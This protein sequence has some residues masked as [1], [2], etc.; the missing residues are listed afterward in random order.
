MKKT[1]SIIL[2]VIAVMSLLFCVPA[3]AAGIDGTFITADDA[4]KAAADYLGTTVDSLSNL[5]CKEESIEYASV[6]GISI[7][8][9]QF[10]LSFRYNGVSYKVTVDPVGV[11]RNYSY[12][13]NKVIVPKGA[14]GYMTEAEAKA[15]ATD[16]AGVSS[17]DAIF[18][19]S[20]FVVE[21]YVG[22]YQFSFLGKT[23]QVSAK[24]NASSKSADPVINV[25]NKNAIVMF[26]IRL[27][28]K[29]AAMFG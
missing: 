3:S 12:D 10:N 2:A 14:S 21:D 24:V 16:A 8:A 28:A 19:S 9:K 25:E 29:I 27:F 13:S 23:Q 26:F 7:S 15:K 17:A 5:E 6:L 4:K 20:K 11:V 1:L 22:Y 18:T